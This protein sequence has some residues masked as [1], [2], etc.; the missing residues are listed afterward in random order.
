M[1]LDQW[2]SPNLWRGVPPCS[3]E[4]EPKKTP[5]MK[6]VVSSVEVKE[7]RSIR[8]F[9]R[10]QQQQLTRS[11]WHLSINRALYEREVI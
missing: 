11:E 5:R 4:A 6:A 3:C 2:Q 7:R 9:A 1:S 10:S 8:I